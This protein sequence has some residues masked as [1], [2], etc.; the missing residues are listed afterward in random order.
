MIAASALKW[1]SFEEIAD[2]VKID[3]EFTPNEKNTALYDRMFK[4]FITIY[5]KNKDIFRRLNS[6]H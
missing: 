2:D 3:R 1:K 4:E 6:G 5:K